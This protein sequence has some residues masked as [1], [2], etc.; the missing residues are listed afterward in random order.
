MTG[1]EEWQPVDGFP[2]YEVSDQGRVRSMKTWHG[3]PG[4]RI[5]AT[6]LNRGGYLTLQLVAPDGRA[7]SHRVHTLVASAF[8]GP[9]STGQEVR[10]LDGDPANAWLSNLAYGSPSENARDSIQH[11]THF[12][13]SKD[14]C[15]HGHPFDVE[16]TYRSKDGRRYCRTCNRRN[17]A[18]YKQRRA[19]AGVA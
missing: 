12:H 15:S 7:H 9:R 6:A 14:V 17:V 5:L 2:G 19:L 4:P 10:H 1:L 13:A 8:L 3:Q 11:G 16:N 18:S